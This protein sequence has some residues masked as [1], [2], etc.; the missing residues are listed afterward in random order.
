MIYLQLSSA[1]AQS[2][3]G[4][5]KEKGV[6]GFFVRGVLPGAE[7]TPP[8]YGPERFDEALEGALLKTRGAETLLRLC[9]YAIDGFVDRIVAERMRAAPADSIKAS[10]RVLL[11]NIGIAAARMAF[12]RLNTALNSRRFAALKESGMAAPRLLLDLVEASADGVEATRK[13]VSACAHPAAAFL[14]S[15]RQLPMLEGWE[16]AGPGL[17]DDYAGAK[18]KIDKLANYQID[19]NRVAEDLE[20][21]SCKARKYPPY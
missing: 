9:P 20:G 17:G 5:F 8:L 21:I 12:R 11:G 14:L 4:R 13:Y 6:A 1:P 2:E 16:P 3:E 10:Y 7:V 19:L 15:P 18:F